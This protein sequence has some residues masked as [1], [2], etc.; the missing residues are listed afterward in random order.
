MPSDIERSFSYFWLVTVAYHFHTK[1]HILIIQLPKQ[2]MQVTMKDG[3][4]NHNLHL[5][6][7][8]PMMTEKKINWNKMRYTSRDKIDIDENRAFVTLAKPRSDVEHGFI[9]RR[10]FIHYVA[11]KKT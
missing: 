7:I 3:T 8:L 10:S 1:Y 9:T 2:A 5:C 6:P 4:A 11:K